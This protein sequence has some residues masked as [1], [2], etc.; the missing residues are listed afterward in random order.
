MTNNECFPYSYCYAYLAILQQWISFAGA[1]KVHGQR[2]DAKMMQLGWRH[3][4]LSTFIHFHPFSWSGWW[5]QTDAA[6]WLTSSFPSTFI[7]VSSIWSTFIHFHPLSSIWSTSIHFHPLSSILS[8]FIHFIPLSSTFI[9]FRGQSD[10]PNW[11]CSLVD[12]IHFHP[13]YPRLSTFIH[14]HPLSSMFIHFNALSSIFIYFHGQRD[15]AKLMQQ[16]GWRRRLSSIVSTSIHFRP[17]SSTFIYFYGHWSGW[18]CQIDDAARLTS[19]TL[20]HFIHFIHFHPFLSMLSTFIDF[21]LLSWSGTGWWYQTVAAAGK[22]GWRHRHCS[23]LFSSLSNQSS[24]ALWERMTSR[25]QIFM[26]KQNFWK[27][28]RFDVTNTKSSAGLKLFMR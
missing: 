16:L 22:L 7:H 27:V 17:F 10:E 9:H 20:I 15:D 19:S 13:F 24:P 4:L 14:F 18:W 25:G 21:H 3:P 23:N 11:C 26:Q 28:N 1:W 5:C 6:S 12:I 8:T 2:D